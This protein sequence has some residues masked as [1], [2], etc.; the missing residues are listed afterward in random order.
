[1]TGCCSF[2]FF[3]FDT[4]VLRA[5]FVAHRGYRYLFRVPSPHF[6]R[7]S[8]LLPSPS[9]R[10]S[11]PHHVHHIS[12]YAI[13]TMATAPT[14]SQ[15]P[16]GV[17]G[18]GFQGAAVGVPVGTQV[19]YIREA[20]DDT[21]AQVSCILAPFIPIVGCVSFCVNNDAPKDSNRKRLANIG[22]AL[23]TIVFLIYITIG[24]VE[25]AKRP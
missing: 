17:G 20:P 14:Y 1:M 16:P 2:F 23:A 13:D 15:L 9:R 4:F 11:A 25:G 10:H 5:I 24:V 22:C 21:C 7:L 3:L 19:V 12:S 6:F 18:G 8:F